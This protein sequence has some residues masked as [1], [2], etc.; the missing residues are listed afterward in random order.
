MLL[1][2]L[3]KLTRHRVL[4]A[5]IALTCTSATFIPGLW[6]SLFS[7]PENTSIKFSDENARSGY[8]RTPDSDEALV[9]SNKSDIN[10]P[11]LAPVKFSQ[12]DKSDS[13]WTTKISRS[14]DSPV[15]AV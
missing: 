12:S 7:K 2:V 3:S 15:Y 14:Q 8:K 6:K 1:L 9:G 10:L 5:N 13:T 11:R 4:E